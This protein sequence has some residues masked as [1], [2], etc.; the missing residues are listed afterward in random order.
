MIFE[1]NVGKLKLDINLKKVVNK[2]CL[3]EALLESAK[4]VHLISHGHYL[5]SNQQHKC[6]LCK[7]A[8]VVKGK[9]SE[10]ALMCY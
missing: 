5:T 6:D 8:L 2:I 9:Y 3:H 10:E 7:K 4:T 1:H